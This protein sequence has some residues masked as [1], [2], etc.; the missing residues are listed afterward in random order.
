MADTLHGFIDRRIE[1][2]GDHALF[3][4]MTI[5]FG[6]RCFE[7]RHRLRACYGIRNLLHQYSLHPKSAS[8]QPSDLAR[9]S[10]SHA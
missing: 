10:D 6:P 2:L 7:A 1:L 9:M 4:H 3:L 8:E 5:D